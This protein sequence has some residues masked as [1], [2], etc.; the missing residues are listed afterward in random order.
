MSERTFGNSTVEV[1]VESQLV[2]LCTCIRINFVFV[3]YLHS[4][5]SHCATYAYKFNMKF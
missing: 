2:V 5:I 1:I 4:S 3:S